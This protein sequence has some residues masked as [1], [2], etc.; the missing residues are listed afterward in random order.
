MRS[1]LE[2]EK[3]LPDLNDDEI[4]VRA[5]GFSPNDLLAPSFKSTWDNRKALKKFGKENYRII[6]FISPLDLFKKLRMLSQSEGKKIRYLE[7]NTHGLPGAL[8]TRAAES[9]WTEDGFNAKSAAGY[10]TVDWLNSTQIR[11]EFLNSEKFS[12]KE[13][14]ALSLI[15]I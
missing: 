7:L 10:I 5:I 1:K 4:A 3:P 12:F 9:S 13:I 11:Q 15:H 6:E 14:M 8:Y 2:K